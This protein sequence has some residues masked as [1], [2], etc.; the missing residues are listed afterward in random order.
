MTLPDGDAPRNKGPE[1]EESPYEEPRNKEPRINELGRKELG[2]EDPGHQE[3]C[4]RPRDKSSKFD[5][6]Q[7]RPVETPLEQPREIVVRWAKMPQP[8]HTRALLQLS[9]H[10]IAEKSKTFTAHTRSGRG[11]DGGDSGANG[12][13]D[14]SSVP[15]LASTR[16]PGNEPASIG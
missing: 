9:D 13:A 7:E 15:T 8:R 16:R 2:I 10:F 12:S 11:T 5:K 6:P 4:G 14:H 1:H 3:S